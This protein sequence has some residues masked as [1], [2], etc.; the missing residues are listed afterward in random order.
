M[1][2]WLFLAS[3]PG[4]TPTTTDHNQVLLAPSSSVTCSQVLGWFNE[5]NLY[6][7]QLF[8]FF[9]FLIIFLIPLIM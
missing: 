4:A 5:V 7:Y 9:F 3:V 6:A 2:V 1:P 8:G